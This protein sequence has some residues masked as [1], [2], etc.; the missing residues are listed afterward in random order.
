MN[1]SRV[2]HATTPKEHHGFPHL[3]IIIPVYNEADRIDTS[4]VELSQWAAAQRFTVEI[5]VVDDGSEDA[6]VAKA[7]RIAKEHPLIRVLEVPHRGKA[8]AVLEGFATAYGAIV[9]FMDVDIAT[10]LNTW[11]QCE[12]A[13]ANGADVVIASRE[14]EGSSRI[15]EPGYRHAM[16]RVFNGLV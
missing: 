15:D 11:R 5:I 13:F 14:G 10:P 16:G 8:N 4:L 12:A 3:S 1:Q 6:T 7:T 2:A 9:G